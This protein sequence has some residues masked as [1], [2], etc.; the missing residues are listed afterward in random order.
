LSQIINLTNL[1]SNEIVN[2]HNGHLGVHSEGI[3]GEGSVFILE[4]E[5]FPTPHNLTIDWIE[6][7]NS[8]GTSTTLDVKEKESVD[9]NESNDIQS[10]E[11]SRLFFRRALVVDDSVLNRKMVVNVLKEHFSEVIQAGDGLEAL[12][13]IRGAMAS[14]QVFDIVFMDSIMPNMGGIEACRVMRS[15][16]FTN[17]IIAVT[18]NILPEDVQE[19]ADAGAN[20]ILIKP[21]KIEKLEETLE[22]K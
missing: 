8:D 7:N 6:K 5:T 19:Y 9:L 22:S 4:L 13:I 15:L 12:D 2:R 3:P 14:N 20:D 21:L 1:V 18:G 17:M 16:G 11:V 10:A